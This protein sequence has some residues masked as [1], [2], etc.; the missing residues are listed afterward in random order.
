MKMADVCIHDRSYTVHIKYPNKDDGPTL[1][2]EWRTRVCDDCDATLSYESVRYRPDGCGI[3]VQCSVVDDIYEMLYTK[4]GR[5]AL[6]KETLT[7][8]GIQIPWFWVS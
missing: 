5:L 6:V 1:V 2:K 3:E 4:K 8:K 7:K